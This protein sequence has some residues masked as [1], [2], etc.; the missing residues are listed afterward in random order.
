[1]KDNI[2]AFHHEA[3]AEPEELQADIES[4]YD[5]ASYSNPLR[6]QGLEIGKYTSGDTKYEPE[7]QLPDSIYVALPSKV[8]KRY[9]PQT[10][11]Q[12]TGAP[13]P[14]E[15]SFL[16]INS[17]QP[18]RI[19]SV[20]HLKQKEFDTHVDTAKSVP[21]PGVDF[22]RTHSEAAA[23]LERLGRAVSFE[24][25]HSS[26]ISANRSD[27]I[28]EKRINVETGDRIVLSEQQQTARSEPSVKIV[29]SSLPDKKYD[30]LNLSPVGHDAIPIEARAVKVEQTF[31]TTR[32]ARDDNSVSSSQV[33]QS[34]PGVP[35]ASIPQIQAAQPLNTSRKPANKS[36][37]LI[38]LMEEKLVYREEEP[39]IHQE[40]DAPRVIRKVMDDFVQMKKKQ[41]KDSTI[42]MKTIET[43]VKKIIQS[44]LPPEELE[45][46]K[47][48]VKEIRQIIKEV[49]DSHPNIVQRKLGSDDMEFSLAARDAFLRVQI[50]QELRDRFESRLVENNKLMEKQSVRL[51]E[52]MIYD[53]L[54]P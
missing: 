18:E 27:G 53:F 37:N 30:N 40:E 31:V 49:V 52:S 33:L 28:V 9:S 38:N 13:L 4:S 36:Q 7:H 15:P 35:D 3:F 6:T 8:S 5:K 41:V 12:N 10:K 48:T 14:P 23:L 45:S 54:N 2:N 29:V 1:M 44:E 11:E 24:A 34:E 16:R 26:Q 19:T 43:K 47:E 22:A 25:H 42:Q 50:E 20:R 21:L 51:F 46:D 32:K 17:G 39:E